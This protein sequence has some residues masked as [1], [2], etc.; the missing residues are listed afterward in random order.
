MR[1]RPIFVG[2]RVLIEST[3]YLLGVPTDPLVVRCLVRGPS[4]S[5]T[6]LVYPAETLTRRETGLYEASVTVNVP[7]LWHV[8]WEGAG[9]VDAVE[10]L[11]FEVA[12]SAVA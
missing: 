6:V 7:G 3:F 4:G 8:R 5:L 2:Q 1:A 11:A 10:E 12:S 9:T